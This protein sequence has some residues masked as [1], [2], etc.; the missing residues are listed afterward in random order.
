MDTQEI[1]TEARSQMSN[2][3]RQMMIRDSRIMITLL[4][5]LTVMGVGAVLYQARGI[6]LP[7]ALAVFL[8]TSLIRL[9]CF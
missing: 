5:I 8:A 7:F 3:T 6:V 9:F 4:S 2:E 1:L